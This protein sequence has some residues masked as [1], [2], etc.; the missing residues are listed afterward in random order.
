M[1]LKLRALW[2]LSSTLILAPVSAYACA[3]GCG[4]FGVGTLPLL[5]NEEGGTVFLE[6]DFMDQSRNWSGTGTAPA[7]NNPDKDLRTNF[8]T[9]G[10][11]YMFNSDWGVMA[12][13]P[14]WDRSLTTADTP[15]DIDTFHHD[16]LGDIRLL[17]VYSG[18]STDMSSGLVFGVKLP[19]GDLSF[20]GFDR[21][22]EIGSGST[23]LLLGFYHAGALTPDN[24]WGWF[25]QAIGSHAVSERGSYRPGDEADAATGIEYSS[26]LTIGQAALMPSLQLVNS[27]RLHDSGAAA[28]P[29]NS[30]YERIFVAP[31]AELDYSAWKL[32]GAVEV[33]I[34]QHFNGNQV[35]ASVLVKVTVGYAF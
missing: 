21:D 8:F 25:V 9:A 35:A 7:A 4:V 2:A 28:D 29:P 17:G 23:D 15:T 20:P 34:Y 19:T 18:F 16:A 27:W 1:R 30:G 5:P 6:Y 12:E 13:V 24:K 26:G 31:G 32:Y 11:Q 22:T 3:C 33:P 14:F 10:A